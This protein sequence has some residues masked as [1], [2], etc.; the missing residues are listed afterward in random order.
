MLIMIPSEGYCQI[1]IASDEVQLILFLVDLFEKLFVQSA[2]DWLMNLLSR[3]I[4][5][6]QVPHGYSSINWYSI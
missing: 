2:N 1:G 5:L 4:G 3:I 6:S